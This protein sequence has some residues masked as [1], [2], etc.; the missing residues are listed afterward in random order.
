MT[1]TEAREFLRSPTGRLSLTY[2]AII[3]SL[4]LLFSIVLFTIASSQLR[5]PLPPGRE[6][7]REL[8]MVDATQVAQYLDAKADHDRWE[9][10]WTLVLLNL[11]V[12]AVGSWFSVYLA[13][14]TMEPITAAMAQQ[15]QFVSDASH[16]LRTPL[17][18]L[19][20]MNEV[21]LGRKKISDKEARDL[22]T[23][24]IDEVA[25]LHE[26]TT[27][28]LGLVGADQQPIT[29]KEPVDLQQAVG[30]ALASVV[31]PAQAKDLQIDDATTAL[32]VLTH[33]SALI[34]V[35]RIILDNAVKYSP[36][37]G[38]IYLTT[39]TDGSHVHLSVRDEG[40]GI[41]PEHL[42]RIFDRFYRADNA[43]SK[44]D[45]S[46]YGLGLA[47]AKSLSN[48]YGFA[49]Q[50][51]SQPANGATFRITLP[52]SSSPSQQKEA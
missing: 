3:M 4:T 34:Q 51:S 14:K 11:C 23:Q 49:L 9:L 19:R 43:R 21:V 24:N 52:I 33:R 2:L 30:E 45:G 25:K 40:I 50:A 48:R 26:L 29:T 10:F 31:T 17:T 6:L 5:R 27:S 39:T 12:G 44:A 47:I 38:T 15:V 13:K 20:A 42:P 28:L 7:R 35:L 46:G 22:A 8:A 36:A 16:E 41:P 1:T 37:N 32:H 18:S